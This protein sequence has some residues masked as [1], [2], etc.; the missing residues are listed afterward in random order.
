MDSIIELVETAKHSKAPPGEP[1][2]IEDLK[3][4][5]LNYKNSKFAVFSP[6]NLKSHLVDFIFSNAGQLFILLVMLPS[7]LYF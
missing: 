3:K 6:C 2:R 1:K 5:F 4:K 7:C